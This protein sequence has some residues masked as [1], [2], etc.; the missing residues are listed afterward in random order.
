MNNCKSFLALNIFDGI[1]METTPIDMLVDSDNNSSIDEGKII[2]DFSLFSEEELLDEF[3]NYNAASSKRKLIFIELYRR[4]PLLANSSIDDLC[5]VYDSSYS[6]DILNFIYEILDMLLSTDLYSLSN[7]TELLCLY[8]MSDSKRLQYTLL[9]LDKYRKLLCYG[10]DFTED[11]FNYKSILKVG[12][13]L[14]FN[15][16]ITEHLSWF[17][18]FLHNNKLDEFM[19]KFITKDI[20]LPPAVPLV[21]KQYL[22]TSIDTSSLPA[23]FKQ[24]FSMFIASNKESIQ[25]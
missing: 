8:T 6:T 21:Y 22:L 15:T 13:I 17:V 14:P 19:Y 16:N 9:F 20:I 10:T 5:R 4:D 11:I 18:F 23:E 1:P 7:R 12:L 2:Y 3:H 24:K 25:I